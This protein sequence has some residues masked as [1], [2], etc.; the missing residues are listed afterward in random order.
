MTAPAPVGSCTRYPNLD[1]P[2]V[3]SRWTEVVHDGPPQLSVR[4]LSCHSESFDRAPRYVIASGPDGRPDMV[5]VFHLRRP[6]DHHT[7]YRLEAQVTDHT[8][9]P[10]GA[11]DA[12]S[13]VVVAPSSYTSGLYVR[14]GLP[15]GRVQ[16]AVAAVRR[17]VAVAARADH[18]RTILLPHL[19]V[20]ATAWFEDAAWFPTG[21]SAYLDLRGGQ[22]FNDYLARL[23]GKR[24]RETTRERR[25]FAAAGLRIVTS[26][27]LGTLDRLV[28][29][30][31]AHY[32]RH[33]L[34]TDPARITAQFRAL[35]EYYGDDL[36]LLLVVRGD[37]EVGHVVVVREGEWLVPKLAAF[38]GRES[39]AYFEAG[40]YRVIE[41]ALES[42]GCGLIEYGGAAI[43]AK[44]LR[45][46]TVRPLVGAVLPVD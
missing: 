41:C 10:P 13:V 36:L 26:S 38:Q 14:S 6:G 20:N 35:T 43:D 7:K 16:M 40:Y 32:R 27:T 11:F 28:E 37:V 30:Q 12:P 22:S 18:A 42:L 45:G 23:S 17:S 5:A 39:Y 1:E 29:R 44:V 8:Q 24:R 34:A 46:C 3:A 2:E 15:I 4:W 19:D 33:G 21:S 31:V 25:A 9:V